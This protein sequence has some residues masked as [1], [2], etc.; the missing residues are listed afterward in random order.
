M[1]EPPKLR[2]RGGALRA[3]GL[4]KGAQG[5]GLAEQSAA[6]GKEPHGTQRR[7]APD[8]WSTSRATLESLTPP[9]FSF[10]PRFALCS[11]FCSFLELNQ[12]CVDPFQKQT[13]VRLCADGVCSYGSA[14][15]PQPHYVRPSFRSIVDR[16]RAC[17]KHRPH[18]YDVHFR[19]AKRSR[20]KKSVAR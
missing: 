20:L 12:H 5:K 9:I 15:V 6:G 10:F 16:K 3:G 18:D 19:A 4:G 7:C 14:P 1:G 13:P 2:P 11:A 8:L 17:I